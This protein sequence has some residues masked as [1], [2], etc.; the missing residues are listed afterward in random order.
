MKRTDELLNQ[1][2]AARILGVCSQTLATW[3]FNDRGPR[4]LRVEGSIR[5][6][7]SD[8]ELYIRKCAVTPKPHLY[9]FGG[10]YRREAVQG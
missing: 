4:Y 3:R 2:D 1:D 9:R 6:R 7:K 8:V 5:Y 10:R